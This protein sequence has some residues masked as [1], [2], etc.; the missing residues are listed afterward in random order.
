MHTNISEITL[1]AYQLG[2]QAARE[3]FIKTSGAREFIE[4]VEQLGAILGKGGKALGTASNAFADAASNATLLGGFLRDSPR[5]G[6]IAGTGLAGA[7]L[8]STTLAHHPLLT[9]LVG[10]AGMIGGTA[11]AVGS[12]PGILGGSVPNRVTREIA[13][14]ATTPTGLLAT[15]AGVVGLPAALIGYGRLKERQ[16]NSFF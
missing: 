8:A 6:L 5:A 11:L 14:H 2:Q 10:P 1:R 16:E 7:G 3:N 9:H 13:A 12:N 4:G 15:M